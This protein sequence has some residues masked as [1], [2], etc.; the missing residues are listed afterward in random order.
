MRSVDVGAIVALHF[1]SCPHHGVSRM[2]IFRVKYGNLLLALCVAV[3]EM[4]WGC[5]H[6]IF[7]P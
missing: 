3:C 2:N 6:S 1:Y 5:M 7:A 4:R